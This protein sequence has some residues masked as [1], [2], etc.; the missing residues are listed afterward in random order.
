MAK[1]N[2]IAMGA[3]HTDRD[4]LLVI[5][6]NVGY[7]NGMGDERS[8][9]IID[10]CHSKYDI[11]PSF[12]RTN[13][14]AEEKK[15]GFSYLGID[16]NM[17]SKS[18]STAKGNEGQMVIKSGHVPHISR[19]LKYIYE[20]YGAQVHG[21]LYKP[22]GTSDSVTAIMGCTE[23]RALLRQADDS[24]KLHFM[25]HDIM[26]YNNKS[27]TNEPWYIRRALLE[28]VM[29]NVTSPFVEVSTVYVTDA[30]ATFRSIVQSGGEGLI[31]KKTDGLYVPGKKPAN[32]WVKCKREVTLDAIIIGINM[33]G[34]GKNKDLFKSLDVGL[35]DEDT[36][37]IK[38][39]GSI[40]SG[41]SDQ[42]RK[43]IYNDVE[44]FK[45]RVIEVS[46]ME[47]NGKSWTMRHGRLLRF[48]DDKSI[49]Q[50]TKD[51]IAINYE[52]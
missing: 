9:N 19:W 6:G 26:M 48:R 8:G 38:S 32:N 36:K 14:I 33:G 47:F 25:V 42:L 16:G 15:D 5:A 13:W 22:G 40:H 37:S 51:G 45:N 39:I 44:S 35:W 29:R 12:H 23:D 1:N 7:D 41:I 3:T 50:C 28:K 43:D 46:A 34:S 4:K 2:T 30:Q 27:V 24:N 20:E 49:E 21:E 11:I 52:L 18:L 17:V 31:F 10:Y